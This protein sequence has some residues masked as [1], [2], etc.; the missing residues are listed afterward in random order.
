MIFVDG[1]EQPD[2]SLTKAIQTVTLAEGLDPNVTHTIRVVKRSNARSSTAAL[3]SLKLTD[4]EK[5]APPAQKSKLIEFVGDSITVGYSASAEASTSSSWSTAT[6]DGTKTYSEYIANAFGADYSVIAVSG[7]GIARNYGN[8]TERL[9]P[10]LYA[11]LD[12][13]N[14]EGVKYD[15]ARQA[16]VIVINAG[17]NDASGT[18]TGLSKDEFMATLKTFLLDVRA[19]NPNAEIIYA[20]GM[21]SAGWM[22]QIKTVITELRNAGDTHI[23]F[24]KL[25]Q[26]SGAESGIASHPTAEAYI[27]RGDAIIELITQLTGWKADGGASEET[28]PPVETTEAPVETTEAPAETPAVTEPEATETAPVE[29]KSGCGASAISAAAVVGAVATA[30]ALKKKKED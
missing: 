15:F 6:E 20:Y 23:T 14:L 5:L 26:C 13:Y 9:I 10:L 17:T 16:D 28:E 21:M 3:V 11:S 2:V 27:S 4:G 8:T 7:R 25:N 12:D 29:V 1:V 24:L 18:V 22:P 30:V 19:K